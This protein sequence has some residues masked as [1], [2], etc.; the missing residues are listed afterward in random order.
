MCQPGRLNMA[1]Q[2]TV[3]EHAWFPEEQAVSV[4]AAR[5]LRGAY[6][7]PAGEAKEAG[8]EAGAEADSDREARER[9]AQWVR[10]D[11]A[12][13]LDV[14]GHR[15]MLLQIEEYISP[16]LGTA[17]KLQAEPGR[18]CPRWASARPDRHCSHRMASFLIMS[19]AV[20]MVISLCSRCIMLQ[21]RPDVSIHRYDRRPW[22]S[23][24]VPK[25]PVLIIVLHT[26][27]AYILS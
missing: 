18:C 5:R 22:H 12:Q 19:C 8:T 16:A 13:V 20:H 2:G 11:S 23:R 25:L 21:Q 14:Q 10:D 17:C 4:Q 7:L 27:P 6:T 9:L 24:G 3:A 1:G 26:R 15:L